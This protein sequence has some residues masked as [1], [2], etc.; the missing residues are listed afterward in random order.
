[1]TG[2]TYKRDQIFWLVA[3]QTGVFGIFMGGFGPAI[4]LLQAEQGTSAAVAGLHGTALGIASIIAG[5]LNAPMV[6][7]YGRYKSMWL[8]LAIF[9]IGAI[10]FV[11]FPEPWQTIPSMLFAGIGVSTVVNNSFTYLTFHYANNSA[12][13]VSQANGVNSAFFL[14]GNFIIGVIAGTTFSWRL[15]LLVCIPFAIALYFFL[16]RHHDPEHIPDEEGPQRGSLSGRYWIAW[17]G[18]TFSI[19]AEFAFA[20]W[21]SALV[22]LRTGLSPARSITLVLGYPLG[23]MAGR[24]FGTYVLPKLSRDKRLIILIALQFAG[25]VIVW[26]SH[27]ILL[28]FIGILFFGLGTSMQFALTSLR[29]L[30]FGGDKPDLA[31]G[32]SSL[33]AGIAI[34][35]SPFLLGF[36][37][38][39]I[40]ISRGFLMVP[41][42]IAIA[43]FVVVMVPAR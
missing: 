14:T 36:L 13:A 39:Q 17:V 21:S 43:F 42:A 12:R 29:I 7:K 28:S 10:A 6:H 1:L 22:H 34:G 4:P 20:Y 25:F 8:G 24:W 27:Q 3:L 18:L 33:A 26:N 37:S 15:G 5:Y 32:K 2:L 35:G 19:A 38:D 23:M 9:N 40:G 30:H 41:I 16:G 31:M 11:I